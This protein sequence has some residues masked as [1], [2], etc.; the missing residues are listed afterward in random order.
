LRGTTSSE[1][2]ALLLG[3]YSIVLRGPR[4]ML[5]SP[6]ATVLLLERKP[7]EGQASSTAN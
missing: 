6:G 3:R 7:P 1:L 5:A 4:T 2:Q